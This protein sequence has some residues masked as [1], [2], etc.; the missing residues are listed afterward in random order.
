MTFK[1][2]PYRKKNIL[3]I[4]AG[5]ISL[6]VVWVFAIKPT[7]NLYRENQDISIRLQKEIPTAERLSM[8]EDK[9]KILNQKL[10]AFHGDTLDQEERVLDIVS[11]FCHKNQLILKEIPATYA[12]DEKDFSILTSEVSVQGGY[13][14]LLKLI[15]HLEQNTEAGRISSAVFYS[16]MDNKTKRKILVLKMYLQNIKII[17]HENK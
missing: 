3:L 7:I 15:A 17:K 12:T 6:V 10:G 16:F 14:G 4:A 5:L 2:L 9:L 1:N 11:S 13:H 8:L